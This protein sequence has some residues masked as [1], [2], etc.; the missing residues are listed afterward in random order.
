MGQLKKVD[1]V[2]FVYSHEK[3]PKKEEES[4]NATHFLALAVHL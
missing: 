1:T 3:A 4:D 2:R